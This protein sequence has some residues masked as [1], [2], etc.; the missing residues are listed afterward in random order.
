MEMSREREKDRE[1]Q[2]E[3]T[4]RLNASPQMAARPSVPFLLS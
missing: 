3:E 4:L 2:K 1:E